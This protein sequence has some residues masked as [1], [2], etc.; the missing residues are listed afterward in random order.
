MLFLLEEFKGIVLDFFAWKCESIVNT[1]YEF[2]LIL[3]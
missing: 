1:F 3:V 2:N